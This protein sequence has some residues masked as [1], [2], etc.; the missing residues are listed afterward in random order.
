MTE[1][2]KYFKDFK[3]VIESLKDFKYVN[4][5]PTE[6]QTLYNKYSFFF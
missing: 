3:Y 5:E 4:F 2:L 6:E 1:R